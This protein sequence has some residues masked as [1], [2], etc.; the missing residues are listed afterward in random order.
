MKLEESLSNF[1]D[2]I[3]DCI[4]SSKE[5]CVVTH[6]DCDGLTSGSII[7]KALIRSGAKVTTRTATEMND[8]VIKNMQNDSRNFHV[9]TDLGGG[10]AKQFDEALGESLIIMKSQKKNTTMSRS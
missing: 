4:K 3:S 7:A 9:I 5:I 2:K 1:D 8:F 6:I 10:F